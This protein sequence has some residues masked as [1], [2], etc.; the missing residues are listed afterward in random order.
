MEDFDHGLYEHISLLSHSESTFR[1]AMRLFSVQCRFEPHTDPS[2]ED[3]EQG[4][5]SNRKSI[6]RVVMQVVVQTY[7]SW[8]RR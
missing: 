8:D 3:R 2:L 6:Q 1:E 5:S 7:S 4:L